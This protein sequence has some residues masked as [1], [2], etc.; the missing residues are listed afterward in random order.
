MP[1][2]DPK[3]IPILDDIIEEDKPEPALT[4]SDI[5]D[6]DNEL[7]SEQAI[8]SLDLFNGTATN[9]EAETEE[10]D[11]GSID[12][13]ISP[14]LG[15]LEEAEEEAVESA[16]IDYHSDDVVAPDINLQ[17]ET[18]QQETVQQDTVS[19]KDDPAIHD[20]SIEN[21][22]AAPAEAVDLDKIVDE[23][24]KQ[25]IPDLEQQL[26]FL[27]LQALEDRLPEELIEQIPA[28]KKN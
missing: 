15:D 20:M 26:R 13:F 6:L 3:S 11:I 22:P 8:D 18:A 4:E 12:Q 25:L 24:V 2:Y 27:V 10:S 28:D 9:S 14:P 21:M 1:D 19:N 17:H 16:L 5:S 23:I 7:S